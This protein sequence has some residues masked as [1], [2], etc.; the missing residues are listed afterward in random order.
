MCVCVYKI[1]Y[2]SNSEC[3]HSLVLINKYVSI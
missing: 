1:S 2:N 3:Y